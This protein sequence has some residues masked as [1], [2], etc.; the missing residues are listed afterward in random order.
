[1][2]H[3]SILKSLRSL[4][5]PQICCLYFG[6]LQKHLI[7][8]EKVNVRRKFRG[9][10]DLCWLRYFL[11]LAHLGLWSWQPTWKEAFAKSEEPEEQTHYVFYPWPFQYLETTY[12]TLKGNDIASQQ[13][14]PQCSDGLVLHL[15]S[16]A[17]LAQ[18]ASSLS[19]F[20]KIGPGVFHLYSLGALITH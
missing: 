11:Q 12:T 20:L 7:K 10:V 19:H 2:I 1:M 17:V 15:E 5:G 3:N 16:L 18:G 14:T 13:V 8:K 4:T 9:G 6:L